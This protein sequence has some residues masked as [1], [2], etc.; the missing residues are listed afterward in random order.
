MKS[1]KNSTKKEIHVVIIEGTKNERC[2]IWKNN[3]LDF[4][5]RIDKRHK[6]SES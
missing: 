1:P 6:T 5:S 2:D 3:G 4:F